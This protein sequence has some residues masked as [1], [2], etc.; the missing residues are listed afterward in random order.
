MENSDLIFKYNTAATTNIQ[1]KK[2]QC[3]VKCRAQQVTATSLMNIVKSLNGILKKY[4]QVRPIIEIDLSNSIMS[5]KLVYILLENICYALIKKLGLQVRLKLYEHDMIQASGFKYSP[6]HLLS[7]EQPIN[8]NC[9]DFVSYYSRNLN[10]NLAHYRRIVSKNEQE[11][12]DIFCTIMTDVRAFLKRYYG[13]VQRIKEIAEIVVELC[14]NAWE[15][16][17]SDCLID[18]DVANDFQ[19]KDKSD[20]YLYGCINIVILNLSEEKIGDGL[21]RKIL[22][23]DQLENRYQVVREAYEFHSRYFNE[24][25]REDTFWG[26]SAFQDKISGRLDNSKTGGTGLPR[27]VRSIEKGFEGLCCYCC[28]GNSVILFRP[29]TLEYNDEGWIGFNRSKNFKT[30]VPMDRVV[31]HNEF[32]LPGTGFNLA[33]IF[34]RDEVIA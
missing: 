11:N 19:K 1:L 5:D 3:V 8:E 15:H 9:E 33:F 26:I 27:M 28:S 21:K 6:L 22:T 4:I 16:S 17:Q 30:D 31:W 25:Y 29:E 34:K 18:L 32:F 7:R 2:R 10:T 20:N 14:G 12:S 13:D 23:S 24:H